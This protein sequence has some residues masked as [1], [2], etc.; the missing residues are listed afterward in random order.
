MM[1]TTDPSQWDQKPPFVQYNQMKPSGKQFVRVAIALLVLATY[2][3]GLSILARA[4]R[5]RALDV[6]DILL[7]LGLG[8]FA[9]YCGVLIR[10]MTVL[11]QYHTVRGSGANIHHIALQTSGGTLD[12]DQLIPQGA[13]NYHKVS[14]MH[15]AAC[16]DA[17]C[18]R[19][20]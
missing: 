6:G 4:T 5:R 11:E 1:N 18:E 7:T 10:G 2:S 13:E 16:F 12:R 8:C 20:D 3:V 17:S 15:L 9:A 19:P 14:L